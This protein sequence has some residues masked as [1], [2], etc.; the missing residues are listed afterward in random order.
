MHFAELIRY[1]LVFFILGQ[2]TIIPGNI[3]RFGFFLRWIPFFVQFCLIIFFFEFFTILTFIQI[4][5]Y[6]SYLLYG[7]AI[8]ITSISSII[9]NLISPYAAQKLVKS[10]IILIKDIEQRFGVPFEWRY[11][12]KS[13]NTTM[14]LS[15]LAFASAIFGRFVHDAPYLRPGMDTIILMMIF[16]GISSV[17][18]IVFHVALYSLILNFL[19]YNLKQLAEL[20]HLPKKQLRN[21]LSY[22]SEVHQRLWSISIAID[23]RFGW[24]L[25]AVLFESFVHLTHAVYSTFWYMD[26]YGIDIIPG[27]TMVLRNFFL[28]IILFLLVVCRIVFQS[29][30]IVR[31][32]L[33]EN[34][35]LPGPTYVYWLVSSSTSSK[36]F[37]WT[38]VDLI[39]NFYQ[40]LVGVG[41]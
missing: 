10:C 32:M 13:F 22:V 5:E 28:I 27:D 16:V 6:I 24:Q 8:L 40:E 2:S 26:V 35:S 14:L 36:Y 20:N 19:N 15:L 4:T 21:I 23:N 1:E 11:F 38:S 29:K 12:V 30:V 3:L 31:F 7:T 33:H 37:R 25:L 18:Y 9:M 17:N 39:F 34:E 41:T